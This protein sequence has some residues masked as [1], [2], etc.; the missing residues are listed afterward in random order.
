MQLQKTID[1]LDHTSKHNKLRP[2]IVI[3]FAAETKNVEENSI[4]KLNQKNCDWIIANDVSNKKIGFD[5]NYNEVK[6]FKKN[7]SKIENI[8]YNTKEMIAK[9]LVK[10]IS[11]ELKVDG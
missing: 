3:G 9:T 7:K 1:I 8:S 11:N 6:I 2:K 4:N 10:E 5:S